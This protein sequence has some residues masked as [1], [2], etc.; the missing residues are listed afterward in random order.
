MMRNMDIT[1][2]WEAQVPS[3][4]LWEK[5]VRPWSFMTSTGSC[6]QMPYVW[7]CRSSCPAG[8]ASFNQ[9]GMQMDANY[10][11]INLKHFSMKIRQYTHLAAAG[12]FAAQSSVDVQSGTFWITK[13]CL[14]ANV[15]EEYYLWSLFSCISYFTSL[16]EIVFSEPTYISCCIFCNLYFL[17]KED[18]PLSKQAMVNWFQEQILLVLKTKMIRPL[19]IKVPRSSHHQIWLITFSNGFSMLIKVHSNIQN[20]LW[21]WHSKPALMAPDKQKCIL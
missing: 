1:L 3:H 10:A 16:W 7:K 19:V 15:F 2:K 4:P 11:F 20:H 18:Y 8:R 14:S 17:A 6:T 21:S 9:R 12:W 5:A 13:W